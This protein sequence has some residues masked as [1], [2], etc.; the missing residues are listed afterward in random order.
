MNKECNYTMDER[1]VIERRIDQTAEL[2]SVAETQAKQIVSEILNH[3]EGKMLSFTDD[4]DGENFYITIPNNDGEQEE[5]MVNSVFLKE[6]DEDEDEIMVIADNN[7][8][9]HLWEAKVDIIVLLYF[10]RDE[11]YREMED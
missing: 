3:T 5:H 1:K 2:M 6:H 9:Y 10:M 11:L 7:E 4:E 8:E